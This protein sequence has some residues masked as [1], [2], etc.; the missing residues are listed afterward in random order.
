MLA[1]FFLAILADALAYLLDDVLAYL[2]AVL[3]STC[4]RTV[5][6]VWLKQWK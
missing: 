5:F 4:V 3:A 1:D 2:L 6:T